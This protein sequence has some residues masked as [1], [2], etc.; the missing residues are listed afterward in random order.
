MRL[1]MPSIAHAPPRSRARAG[2]SYASLALRRSVPSAVEAAFAAAVFVGLAFAV[3]GAHVVHGGFSL[4]DWAYASERER[5]SGV[6]DMVSNLMHPKTALMSAGGRP[7]AALYF[8]VTH[9]AFG[10]TVALHIAWDVFL[11][12]LLPALF[13]LVLRELRFEPLHAGA[14]AGLTLVFPAADSTRY[15]PAAAQGMLA[16]CTFLAGFL[17]ALVAFR[18]TGRR[19]L[20]LHAGSL[21]CY[22]LSLFQYEIA[23]A[24]V[25]LAIVAYRSRAP[26]RP[27]LTRWVLDVIVAVAAVINVRLQ[28][29][30]QIAT[31]HDY[32]D[33]AR[34]IQ[35]QSRT[36]LGQ[37]GIQ[38]GPHRLPIPLVALVFVVALALFRLLRR[39]DPIRRELGR[40]LVIAFV[41]IVV[42]GA[43]YAVFVPASDAFY[44]PM[45]MGIGNRTNLA[46]A[47]GFVLLLYSLAMIVGLLATKAGTTVRAVRPR[48]GVA[49]AVAVALMAPL[50]VAW[51]LALNRDREAWDR[52]YALDVHTL[53]VLRGLQAPPPRTTVYTF[54]MP[55]ETAPLV[56]SFAASWDL[57]G[58]V[59]T[60]WNDQS[61]RGIPGASV[62][63]S[64]LGNAADAGITCG[65]QRVVPRGFLYS[66]ADS[67][68]YGRALFVDIPSRQHELVTTA[69]GCRSFV[70][71]YFR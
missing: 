7:I 55:G 37:L 51:V 26:W 3:F 23:I 11:A 60:L 2:W 40:W 70:A 57:T 38:D 35:G 41:G 47:L 45:R 22:A 44:V 32:V 20:F 54:G 71:R 59:R 66:S 10:D 12:G 13:Y 63:P 56:P 61:L 14:I 53:D 50:A 1:T 21:L 6:F 52:A 29:T 17:L 43:G 28:T 39:D 68:P 49:S 25:V 9:F 33:R 15:W 34:T 42:I 19:A 24:G 58:A 67:S 16:V 48:I 64:K 31:L 69:A 27:A 18:T 4:D 30:K 5:A 65:P 8:A 36:L 62:E 46:A